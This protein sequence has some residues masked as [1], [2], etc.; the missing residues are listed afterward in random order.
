MLSNEDSEESS[1]RKWVMCSLV[2]VVNFE[3]RGG[4]V[5]ADREGVHCLKVWGGAARSGFGRWAR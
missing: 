2:G 4:I 3:E 1:V 5:E